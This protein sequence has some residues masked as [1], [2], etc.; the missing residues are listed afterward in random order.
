MKALLLM[1]FLINP[2]EKE[3]LQQFHMTHS[4]NIAYNIGV[5]KY[6]KGEYAEAIYWWRM[7]A[8]IN[9]GDYQAE[10]NIKTAK[11]KLGIPQENINFEPRPSLFA[12]NLFAVLFLIVFAFLVLYIAFCAFVGMRFFKPVIAGFLL[13]AS[14]VLFVF[15]F[16][17][18]KSYRNPEVCVVIKDTSM[19]SEPRKETPVGRVKAGMEFK[20]IGVMDHWVEVETSWGGIG[21]LQR[22]TLRLIRNL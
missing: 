19:Y 15:S 13:F 17:Q 3:L 20:V 2:G 12:P 9:P 4:G 16:Y 6:E 14:L 22:E 10:E 18:W 8:L 5:I 1:L 11:R 21:W 7:A